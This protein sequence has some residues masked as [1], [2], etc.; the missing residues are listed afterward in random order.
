MNSSDKIKLAIINNADKI[1]AVIRKGNDIEIRHDA[2]GVKIIE[3][4]KAVV[5]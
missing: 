5:R 4:K 1:A 2:N 3:V